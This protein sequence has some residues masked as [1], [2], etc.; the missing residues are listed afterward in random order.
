MQASLVNLFKQ[1]IS[2]NFLVFVDF[3]NFIQNTC[4]LEYLEDRQQF[5]RFYRGDVSGKRGYVWVECDHFGSVF[6]ML[7]EFACFVY[8]LRL[9][10][11]DEC[12][13]TENLQIMCD[14]AVAGGL[15]AFVEETFVVFPIDSRHLNEA[16]AIAYADYSARQPVG[17]CLCTKTVKNQR[18]LAR[19]YRLYHSSKLRVE[20]QI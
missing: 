6:K 17:C 12:D 20:N 8:K 2:K 19:H 11:F 3:E 18:G 16:T 15:T 7:D 10:S 13:A 1:L 4:P 9:E 5:F 14:A